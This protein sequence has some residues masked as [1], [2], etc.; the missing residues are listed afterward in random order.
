MFPFSDPDLP[1]ELLPAS[2]KG[3]E[4]HELF[5]EAHDLLKGASSLGV[6]LRRVIWPFL[7]H[8]VTPTSRYVTHVT[9]GA[10]VSSERAQRRVGAPCGR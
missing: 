2:W 6:T 1:E 7:S 9:S 8:S 3:H 10:S 4:A 5:I